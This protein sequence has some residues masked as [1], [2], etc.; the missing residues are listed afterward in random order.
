M[1]FD[2]CDKDLPMLLQ[3]KTF[4]CFCRGCKTKGLIKLLSNQTALHKSAQCFEVI[5]VKFNLVLKASRLRDQ[6]CEIHN[7]WFQLITFKIKNGETNGYLHHFVLTKEHCTKRQYLL[8]PFMR[9]LPSLDK[10]FYAQVNS[11][12][13]ARGNKSQPMVD[14]RDLFPGDPDISLAIYTNGTKGTG[15][16]RRLGK[17][18]HGTSRS[19]SRSPQKITF[20]Y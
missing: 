4:I 16:A 15:P 20:L 17:I 8:P 5:I 2:I 7:Q 11:G 6:I 12:H 1:N 9:Y 3:R 18:E 19:R 14:L 13:P 10:T